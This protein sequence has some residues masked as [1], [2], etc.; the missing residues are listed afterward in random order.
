MKHWDAIGHATLQGGH[1]GVD[2]V[3]TKQTWAKRRPRVNTREAR[4]E[5]R[6]VGGLKEKTN[7]HIK[8]R[9]LLVGPCSFLLCVTHM[10]CISIAQWPVGRRPVGAFHSRQHLPLLILPGGSKR[11]KRA[12]C[13]M[14]WGGLG[15]LDVFWSGVLVETLVRKNG[16]DLEDK[17][18]LEVCKGQVEV[19]EWNRL[20][21]NH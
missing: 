17:H 2:D 12:F 15:G 8:T 14:D 19:C 13:R 7:E 20:N 11:A 21:P 4:G 16:N 1:P 9:P 5:A 18:W 6:D 10:P 3:L